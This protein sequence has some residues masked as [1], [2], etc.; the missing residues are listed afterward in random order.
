MLKATTP[1]SDLAL[2]S[3][4]GAE[5]LRYVT[6]AQLADMRAAQVKDF[7][8]DG[9]LKDKAMH[10]AAAAKLAAPTDFSSVHRAKNHGLQK[11]GLPGGLN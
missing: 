9:A 4:E 6:L 2:R 7:G 11:E 10:E 3:V 8:E 5:V 1:S